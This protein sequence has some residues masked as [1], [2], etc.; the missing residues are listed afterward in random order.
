[1]AWQKLVRLPIRYVFMNSYELG[2][3]IID[4][5]SIKGPFSDEEIRPNGTKCMISAWEWERG[6]RGQHQFE[7]ILT[8][9]IDPEGK[10][11]YFKSIPDGVDDEL[12]KP[13]KVK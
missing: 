5:E 9:F 12:F 7:F 2:R 8:E 13:K 3:F 6:A 4:P 10:A 11:C 1:M